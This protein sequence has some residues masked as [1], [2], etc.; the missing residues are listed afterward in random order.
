MSGYILIWIFLFHFWIM[1]NC[2]TRKMCLRFGSDFA[3][4]N[5]KSPT[6]DDINNQM[7]QIEK[8]NISWIKDLYMVRCN[9]AELSP[10][11][12]YFN[13][14]IQI[15]KLHLNHNI[16]TSLPESLF[17]SSAL[18]SLK[19][20]HLEHNKLNCLSPKHFVTLQNLQILD[21]SNNK[22]TNFG[23]GLFA[24]NPIHSLNLNANQ[25]EL[26]SNDFLKGNISRTLKK[27]LLNNNRLRKIPQC[28]FQANISK[29][30]FPELEVLDLGKN[31]IMELPTEL[32]NST[33][34]SSLRSLIFRHN[35]IEFLSGPVF[36]S[37]YLQNLE[38]IDLGHNQISSVPFNLL[39]NQGLSNLTHVYLDNNNINKNVTE[40]I[41]P[42]TLHRLC[43]LNLAK[44]KLSSVGDI[45]T[46]V[47]R[48]MPGC[49]GR[50]EETCRKPC[51]LDLSHNKLTVQRT[52]FIQQP[53]FLING[54]LDLSYN[55]IS[56]FEVTSVSRKKTT[57]SPNITVPLD[58]TWMYAYGNK[59][60]SVVNL[61]QA[62]LNFDLNQRFNDSS[63]IHPTFNQ[64]IR[65]HVLI[66]FPYK[67]DCNCDMLK[68]LK[69]Q[70]LTHF[71]SAMSFYRFY[72]KKFPLWT[73]YDSLKSDIAIKK[74]KCGSPKHLRNQ[75]LHE[76]K[77]TDLQCLHNRCTNNIK[78]RCIETPDNN[79]IMINC[80]RK[81]IKQMPA[82]K[83]TSSTFQF[84][85]GSNEITDFTKPF[86]TGFVQVILLDL[87]NNFIRNIPE[88]FFDYYPFIMRLNLAG[89]RLVA[90]P[91]DSE[92]RNL[93]SLEFLELTGNIFTC[94]CSGMQL[95]KTL[96]SLNTRIRL[97]KMDQ[98]KCSSPIKVRDRVI[99]NLPDSSFGCPFVNLVLILTLTLSLLL[100]LSVAMFIA[101]V[102]RYYIS[103]FLFIH[104]GWRF[105]YSYAKDKTLYDAFIS[106]SCK[107][108]DWVIDQL[109]NPLE[110]LDPPYNLCLHERD[111]L[112]GVPICD[113]ISKAIEGSKCTICVVSR[114][115]LESDW[116]QFE[117]RVAHCLATVEKKTRLLVILKEEIPKDKIQGDLKFYMKTFT[118]LDSAQPLFWS[119][120]L[121]D[122]PK[123][124][125]EEIRE[126]NQQ[127]EVI[128]LE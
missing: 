94:N 19:E 126:D 49:P 52:N 50:D 61:V 123:P 114:N 127:R 47:L 46:K 97:E 79:T 86:V 53:H 35:K 78:C 25:L 93:H 64:L 72:L 110:N 26:L 111:F 115:W 122:L 119:R 100:I 83:Q 98:I 43:V 40:D 11:T 22:F 117:F 1:K 20:L 9:I 63:I 33:N 24:S 57:G 102:F 29:T 112:I 23:A 10:E 80:N 21:L 101:Y 121:N 68:Y 41:L 32:F 77:E 104:C 16:I 39:K 36:K 62:A 84:Y 128:E 67:Y 48:N 108:S 120:L 2:G 95:K 37:P 34:W 69:L 87:S 12:F 15:E 60:F 59:H 118:Y 73:R 109:M 55:K 90:I 7:K 74:L 65:L 92:W 91:S 31:K 71:K 88:R 3:I 105:W 96:I 27:M 13:T 89:N 107:D 30:I 125:G 14:F 4:L 56:K 99:Y 81:K 8:R 38:I 44:N 116:C 18:N 75:F 106:Y 85:L 82:V 28:V 58:K 45:I 70:N 54:T 66:S 103:L 17:A 51:K 76:L 124:D 5:C 113:N 6:A 42:V